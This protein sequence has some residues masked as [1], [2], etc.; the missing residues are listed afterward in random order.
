MS[1]RSGSVAIEI[2]QKLV[3]S[4]KAILPDGSVAKKK[5]TTGCSAP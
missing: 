2:A 1:G 4:L 5:T 3:I